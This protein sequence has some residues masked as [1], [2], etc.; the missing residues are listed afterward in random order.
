MKASCCTPSSIAYTLVIIGALNWGLVGLGG[1][2]GIEL[3]LVHLIF[4][5]ID[6]L[7]YLV[8]LL[9]GIAALMSLKGCMGSCAGSCEKPMTTK[10]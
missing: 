10:K 5:S 9:V 6:W 8:Y 7:E 1:F 3:N 2:F 4:G